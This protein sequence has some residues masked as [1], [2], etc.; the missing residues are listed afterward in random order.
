VVVA[1]GL[2]SFLAHPFQSE[3]LRSRLQRQ[4]Q[5]PTWDAGGHNCVGVWMFAGLASGGYV[6]KSFEHLSTKM[7]FLTLVC[8]MSSVFLLIGIC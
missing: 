5:Q 4:Y 7:W 8:I 6:N 2:W 3:V 1:V